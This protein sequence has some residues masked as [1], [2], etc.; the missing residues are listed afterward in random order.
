MQTNLHQI[1]SCVF[2]SQIEYPK[3][4]YLLPLGDT[5]SGNLTSTKTSHLQ[6]LPSMRFEFDLVLAAQC[7]NDINFTTT[8]CHDNK[9]KLEKA[10]N[11]IHK[12][13]TNNAQISIKVRE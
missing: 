10:E 13:S 12:E 5:K 2:A 9:Q 3:F 7:L 11:L 1:L 4:F 6:N 8:K